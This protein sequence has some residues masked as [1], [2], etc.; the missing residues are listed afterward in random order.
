M[1]RFELNTDC[2]TI[3][4]QEDLIIFYEP[5]GAERAVFRIDENQDPLPHCHPEL[6]EYGLV[7]LDVMD[8][9]EGIAIAEVTHL[10][11]LL[12]EAEKQWGPK[13]V[14]RLLASA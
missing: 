14:A 12:A 4:E 2:E 11:T 3:H 5:D 9:R 1:Y 8:A 10:P 6:H 7:A 13:Y